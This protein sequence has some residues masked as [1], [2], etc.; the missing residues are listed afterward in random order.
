MNETDNND[1]SAEVLRLTLPL[2]SR[3][4]VPADPM[5]FTLWYHY[6]AGTDQALKEAL[7]GLI[8][9]K[10]PFTTEL[11]KALFARFFGDCGA[12]L[13]EG[14]RERLRTSVDSTLHDISQADAKAHQY[15]DALQGLSRRL[16]GAS[17]A[18]QVRVLVGEMAQATEHM[19]AQVRGLSRRFES[20][21]TEL[22]QLRQELDKVRR[23]AETDA[24][25][26]VLNRGALDRALETLVEAAHRGDGR[27][28]L[29]MADIDHFKRFND[30]HGHL[31]GDLVLR[32]VGRK[33]KQSVRGADPVGRYGGEEFVVL[34]PHTPL[35]GAMTVS[36][37]I[38]HAIETSRLAR[39]E[40]GE[41]FGSITVSLGVA[42][43][44]RGEVPEDIIQRADQALYLAKQSG[45]NRVVG[46]DELAD[47]RANRR[48]RT[49]ERAG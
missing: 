14:L 45:R 35:P 7:D 39:K 11:N 28:C 6:V 19:E 15:G 26:G 12:N 4:A 10:V 20:T 40:T 29:V 8:A 21:Q 23:E 46:E 17:D 37:S 27:L 16:I 48:R 30:E 33:L 18:T 9:D 25:T 13:V 43:L 34:L 44:R 22:D 5:N 42:R 2:M 32:F 49:T 3:H 1:R 38:R 24:L 41:L 36:E 47:A 31:V